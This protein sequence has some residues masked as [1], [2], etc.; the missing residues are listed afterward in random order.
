MSHYGRKQ[1]PLLGSTRHFLTLYPVKI[2]KIKPKANTK[3]EV[4]QIFSVL[5]LLCLSKLLSWNTAPLCSSWG[6]FTVFLLTLVIT[7]CVCAAAA[8]L[9][10]LTETLHL[11]VGRTACCQ[12]NFALLIS[13]IV[14]RWWWLKFS[15]HTPV[16]RSA[17]VSRFLSLKAADWSFSSSFCSQ[18]YLFPVFVLIVS[19]WLLHG[20]VSCLCTRR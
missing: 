15:V 16:E 13:R 20:K 7:V 11:A 9:S 8:R 6:G 17:P 19:R 2:K 18:L 1:R 5:F 14:S 12:V 3:Q 4:I 10:S